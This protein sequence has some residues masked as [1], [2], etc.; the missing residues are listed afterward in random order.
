[1]PTHEGQE[2]IVIEDGKVVSK[3]NDIKKVSIKV[4]DRK[5]HIFRFSDYNFWTK[6]QDKI[7]GR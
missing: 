6:V 2:M 1:M 5:A 4:A 3:S 7:L